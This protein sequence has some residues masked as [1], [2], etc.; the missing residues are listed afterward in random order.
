MAAEDRLGCTDPAIRSI[1][2]IVTVA[3][4]VTRNQ[5]RP[6][7]NTRLVAE[8]VRR[9]E[10]EAAIVP[11]LQRFPSRCGKLAQPGITGYRQQ[12]QQDQGGKKGP[13]RWRSQ[14]RRGGRAKDASSA[15]V[16]EHNNANT[17]VQCAQSGYSGVKKAC[18]SGPDA[19]IAAQ[20][21]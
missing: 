1:R 10:R 6:P 9:R 4:L 12:A 13:C 17:G 5:P 19:D 20:V 18:D 11:T 3:M 7:P 16:R 14:R 2:V 15:R 8:W 21:E